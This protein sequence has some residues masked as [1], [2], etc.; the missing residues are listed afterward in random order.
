M[1]LAATIGH[2]FGINDPYR[3]PHDAI[4][5]RR[6]DLPLCERD[7]RPFRP[8]REVHSYR[9]TSGIRVDLGH[10]H[11]KRDQMARGTR[12]TSHEHGVSL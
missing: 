10:G 7:I 11:Q 3:P 9:S 12:E 5:N 8:L 4:P 2:R 1:G 6:A